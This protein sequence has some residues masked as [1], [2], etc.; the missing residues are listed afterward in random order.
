M[1]TKKTKT[2]SMIGYK[3]FY[4]DLT[5]RPANDVVFQYKLGRRYTMKETPV[6]C[7]HGFH[8]Y[9][10]FRDVYDYHGVEFDIRICEIKAS[11]DIVMANV[12]PFGSSRKAATN[13]I[14][15]VREFEPREIVE[16][17]SVED[18]ENTRSASKAK[19]SPAWT[20][21]TSEMYRKTVLRR[22]CKRIPIEFR[23]AEQV[24][25]FDAGM[26]IET[27]T[28]ELVKQE[29]EVEANVVDFEE[30]GGQELSVHELSETD[31]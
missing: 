9:P 2:K 4:Y 11:G 21:F 23:S 13:R 5:A 22:L 25:A 30:D 1:T 19:N 16:M 14:T 15:I 20:R 3:A 12:S 28:A 10:E 18:L 31:S 26:E 7:D 6:I 17:M 27:N 29:I 8:F 24:K